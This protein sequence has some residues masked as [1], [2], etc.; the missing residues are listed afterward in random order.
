[1]VTTEWAAPSEVEGAVRSLF[2]GHVEQ[3]TAYAQLLATSAV[4]RGLIGPREVPRL[5]ERHLLNCV[6]VQELVPYGCSV[7]DVG[8]GAGLPGLALAIARPDLSV[9]LLDPLQRRVVWLGE[10]VAWLGVT[11]VQL[12]RGRAETV[13]QDR[14]GR[15]E[16]SLPSEGFDVATARAVASLDTLA[17]W[18]LPLVRGG[19]LFVAIKGQGA[20]AELDAAEPVLRRLRAR[21]WS[22]R[23]CG[24][25]VLAEGT[26][27]VVIVAGSGGPISAPR[28][29]GGGSVRA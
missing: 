19:G 11:N 27:A 13:R 17:G 24:G 15:A 3:A 28:R 14:A 29:K 21:E 16:G 8:S 12:L 25:A 7:V 23:S 1:M 22:V 5:W 20:G 26:T 10:A 6:A 4:E 9:T 18:C 2:G